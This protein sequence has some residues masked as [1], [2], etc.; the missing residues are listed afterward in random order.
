MAH[1]VLFESLTLGKSELNNRI[2]MAPLT[3]L[4]S[5]EPG[6][7]PSPL[8]K[9]YYAQRAS[10]GLIVTEATQVSAQAKGYAGAPGLHIRNLEKRLHQ[11]NQF[12]GMAHDGREHRHGL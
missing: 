10:A 4:R 1:E 11:A 2:V 9:T 12:P 8:A 5:T 6:D 3:R 7:I